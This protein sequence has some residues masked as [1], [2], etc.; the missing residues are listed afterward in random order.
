MTGADLQFTQG[1]IDLIIKAKA[2]T[3]A[4]GFPNY[5]SI[6]ITQKLELLLGWGN[7]GVVRWERRDTHRGAAG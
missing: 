1:G 2:W 6:V 7:H 5:D 3:N 4:V